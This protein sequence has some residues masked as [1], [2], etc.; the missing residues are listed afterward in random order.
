[1]TVAG[2]WSR[3]NIYEWTGPHYLMRTRINKQNYKSLTRLG[4]YHQTTH[5]IGRYS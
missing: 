1:M 2:Y 5:Y 3:Y 4:T